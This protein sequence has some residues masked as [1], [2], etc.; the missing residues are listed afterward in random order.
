MSGGETTSALYMILR[1]LPIRGELPRGK[2]APAGG[3]RPGRPVG[4]LFMSDR[5]RRGKS[6]PPC[7][8]ETS[9]PH[10]RRP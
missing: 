10:N 4:N 9:T 3:S 2:K 7:A 8:N 5:V 6:R 1:A